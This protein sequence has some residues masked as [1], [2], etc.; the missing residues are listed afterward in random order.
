MLQAISDFFKNL[1][2]SFYEGRNKKNHLFHLIQLIFQLQNLIYPKW[3]IETPKMERKLLR[4]FK[5]I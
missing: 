5:N 2:S 3:L 1:S 4:F